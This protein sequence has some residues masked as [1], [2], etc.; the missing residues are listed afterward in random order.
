MSLGDLIKRGHYLGVSCCFGE[1][2]REGVEGVSGCVMDVE[3]E[4]EIEVRG[5]DKGEEFKVKWC[6]WR[7][8]F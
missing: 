8:Q 7:F 3:D 2:C 5:E 6:R 1:K 4:G